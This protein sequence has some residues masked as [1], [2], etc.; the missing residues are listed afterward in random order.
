[1]KGRFGY[2]FVNHPERLKR[3]MVKKGSVFVESWDEALSLVAEKLQ[4]IKEKYGP[5][6]I[7][8]ISSSRGTNEENYLFQKW[9]RA[10]IGTNNI[11]NG[12]RLA[13]GSSFYGMMAAIGQ[14]AMTHAMDDVG[15]A[16]LLLIVGADAYDDNLIFSNKMRKAMREKRQ[17]HRGRSSEDAVG[18]VGK[19]LAEAPAGDRSRLDQWT[20]PPSDRKG[21]PI[22]R[23]CRFKDRGV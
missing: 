13:N 14:G 4:E 19:S 18:A 16:D 3:P 6:S 1:M 11:D 10:C 20:H 22:Q 12:S 7:G 15:K 21:L 17:G 5:Q 8:G 2:D 9:M 23:S